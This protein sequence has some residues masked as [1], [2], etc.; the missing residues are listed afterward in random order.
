M[1]IHFACHSCGKR[2]NIKRELAGK[3]GV[4]PQCETRFRIPLRDSESSLA[5]E[6]SSD[7]MPM[8]SDPNSTSAANVGLATKATAAGSANAYVATSAQNTAAQNT[9]AQNTAAQAKTSFGILD[10]DDDATWYVRPP[11][12]GQYGPAGT[13]M[14][15]DWIDQGRVT[16]S[17]LL[18]RDGWPQWRTASESLPEFAETLRQSEAPPSTQPSTPPST[19]R[20]TQP[21]TQP[22]TQRST[23]RST[24]AR[25]SAKAA[26][27][28]TVSTTF[29]GDAKLGSERRQTQLRRTIFM[30]TLVG[31]M[32]GLVAILVYLVS[33]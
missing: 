28:E 27:I 1:G 23:Q 22:S 11:T 2:L 8:K 20:S 18:W 26:P 15:R 25:T 33:R 31:L 12:G 32:V 13:M 10:V 24:P 16:A 19:Q 21:S 6:D 3:R 7:D 14:L 30:A 29:A 5:A 17:S 9:A 4:C